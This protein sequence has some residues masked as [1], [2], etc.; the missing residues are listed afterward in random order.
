M[1][2]N[3]MCLY[4]EGKYPTVGWEWGSY[5]VLTFILHT[6]IW[7]KKEI[8]HQSRVYYTTVKVQ[9]STEPGLGPHNLKL[10]GGLSELGLLFN[11]NQSTFG[12]PVL[13]L[14]RRRV[15]C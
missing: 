5:R 11:P 1:K 13:W 9:R 3:H 2:L 8:W 7:I 12:L 4:E 10:L 15:T 6:V 14:E